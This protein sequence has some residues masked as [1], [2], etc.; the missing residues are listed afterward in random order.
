MKDEKFTVGEEVNPR[1]LSSWREIAKQ[2]I[3]RWLEDDFFSDEITREML[4]NDDNPPGPFTKFLYWFALSCDGAG[5]GV[6]VDFSERNQQI[7]L[8]D[9]Y[10]KWMHK[11]R[12]EIINETEQS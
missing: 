5:W 4:K 6:M 9:K 3:K 1:R 11:L 10:Y 8:V 2:Q 12:D 7:Y